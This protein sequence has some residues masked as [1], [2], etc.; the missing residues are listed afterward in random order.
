MRT[1]RELSDKF[2]KFFSLPSLR[3]GYIIAQNKTI[4]LLMAGNTT[5]DVT[6]LAI[7][8]AICVLKNK[9]HYAYILDECH[10]I[11]NYVSIQMEEIIKNKQKWSLEP[12]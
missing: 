11:K 2:S 7:N 6:Q 3:I 5:K 1:W 8:A 10:I 12:T 9:Q 4:D